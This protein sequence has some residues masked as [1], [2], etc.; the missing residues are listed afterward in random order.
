MNSYCS[1]SALMKTF[2]SQKTSLRLYSHMH[3]SPE[4]LLT[5]PEGSECENVKPVSHFGFRLNRLHS[6]YDVSVMF[7]QAR[8]WIEE[9]III[10]NSQWVSE[11]V[12]DVHLKKQ[13][14]KKKPLRISIRWENPW[15]RKTCM[16]VQVCNKHLS[17]IWKSP[18]SPEFIKKNRWR[19]KAAVPRRGGEAKRKACREWSCTGERAQ[20]KEKEALSSLIK[21]HQWLSDYRELVWTR[22]YRQPS[23]KSTDPKGGSLSREG[24]RFCIKIFI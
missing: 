19:V 3:S 13:K 24:E 10:K 18:H 8:D 22:K 5:P 9:V 7:D 1:A 2:L 14:R 23:A 12:T 21:L 4:L 16:K 11:I 6:W 17:L 20:L 15:H